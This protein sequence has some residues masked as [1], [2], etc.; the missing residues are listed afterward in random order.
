MEIQTRKKKKTSLNWKEKK[1]DKQH[2]LEFP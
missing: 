2:H 1:I